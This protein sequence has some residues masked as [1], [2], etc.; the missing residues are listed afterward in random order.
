[1]CCFG[2]LS[3]CI[4]RTIIDEALHALLGLNFS[5]TENQVKIHFQAFVT[6]SSCALLGHFQHA[7]LGMKTMAIL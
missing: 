1:M 5:R 2:I 7:L 4:A 3:T 6:S